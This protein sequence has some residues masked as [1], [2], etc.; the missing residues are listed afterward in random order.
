[1][2][3][4][5]WA[6]QLG[7]DHPWGGGS[8]GPEVLGMLQ[9]KNGPES[10]VC[11]IAEHRHP[12]RALVLWELRFQGWLVASLPLWELLSSE[13]APSGQ[14]AQLSM[15]ARWRGPS[16]LPEHRLSVMSRLRVGRWAPA[17]NLHSPL[18]PLDAGSCNPG[19]E[20]SSWGF[21]KRIYTLS[22]YAGWSG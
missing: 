19:L 8:G 17:G 12:Y 3:G 14:R 18:C 11:V 1:M 5:S 7:S 9:L 10:T 15:Q 13:V 16:F 22:Q 21:S 2:D 6:V 20:R 4:L